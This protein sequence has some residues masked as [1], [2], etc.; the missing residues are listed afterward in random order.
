MLKFSLRTNREAAGQPENDRSAR[1]DVDPMAH[2]TI[3][4]MSLRDLADVIIPAEASRPPLGQPA[5]ASPRF[6]WQ[7]GLR[8]RRNS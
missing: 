7:T 8:R 3:G 5:Q 6:S 4:S 2:P 1:W